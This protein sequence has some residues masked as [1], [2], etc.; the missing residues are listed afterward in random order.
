MGKNKLWLL[1]G[2]LSGFM[3]GISLMI[4]SGLILGISMGI[5]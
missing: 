1:L 4:L 2:I 5:L 3:H